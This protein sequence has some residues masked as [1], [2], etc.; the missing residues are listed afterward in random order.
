MADQPQLTGVSIVIPA[1]NEAA[2]I[3]A[4]IARAR[5]ALAALPGIAADIVVVNDGSSDGTGAIAASTGVRVIQHPHNIGYG[6]SLKD[7][8][9]AAVHDT[10][11]ITDAD[12][13]YPIEDI[14]R[15][16][17]Q[18]Q[19]GHDMVVGAR[20]GA[21]YDGGPLKNPLRR[22]LTF[23][24]EFTSG[25]SVPD[26]NSGFRA[27]S[28]ATA[29]RYFGQL[30]DT[31][32]FTTSLTL[33]YMMT[34][35]FVAYVPINYADRVGVTKVRLFRDTLRTLQYI[36]QAILY[37]N[38]IKIFLLLA[39]TALTVTALAVVASTLVGPSPALVLA[40]GGTLVTITVFALG[41]LADLLRQIMTK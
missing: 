15:L 2:A 6:R 25:R 35:R 3:E 13:T 17:Q 22:V 19:D 26:V 9:A 33:A 21:Q 5:A 11:V 31:F 20:T 34:G 24:V 10:V 32:S 36:V 41:L 4:T 23:L 12:G 39:L 28:R 8:I 37:Y 38:P 18:L 40:T 14:A 30:C 27:F 1:Y 29:M 7:G 16:L